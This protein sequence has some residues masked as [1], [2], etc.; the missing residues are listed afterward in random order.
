MS[1]MVHVSCNA[2]CTLGLIKIQAKSEAQGE[3][4]CESVQKTSSSFWHSPLHR[5]RREN[6]ARHSLT[7]C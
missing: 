6:Y 4:Q 3:G 2:S 5:G 1:F 7:F